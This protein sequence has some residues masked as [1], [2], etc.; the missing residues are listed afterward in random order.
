MSNCCNR[1]LVEVKQ[2]ED[3]SFGFT[4]TEGPEGQEQPL[5]LT[6]CVISMELRKTPY[7][8]VE[9]VLTKQIT[10]TENNEGCIYSPT[11][12]EFRFHITEKDTTTIVPDDYY[13]SMY[14][15]RP[16]NTIICIS[17]EGNQSGVFRFCK[18]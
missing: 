11:T 1:L 9:T 2:G 5:D 8:D 12:G 6:G 18:C 13:L 14:V 16:D 3:R 4:V 10:T 17:A 15:K 7:K